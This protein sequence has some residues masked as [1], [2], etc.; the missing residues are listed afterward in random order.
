MEEEDFKAG[1]VG[2]VKLTQG[3]K[4]IRAFW[5]KK[6]TEKETKTKQRKKVTAK[7]RGCKSYLQ[8]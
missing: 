2:W 4:I 1:F 7:K 5:A 6:N 8:I 3:K